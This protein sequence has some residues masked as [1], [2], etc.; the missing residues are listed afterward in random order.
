[1]GKGKSSW[2]I[3]CTHR[4]CLFQRDEIAL[5]SDAKRH[6][7]AH[8]DIGGPSHVVDVLERESLPT[9]VRVGDKIKL[10]EDAILDYKTAC[11]LAGY[12]VDLRAVR[13]VIRTDPFGTGGRTRLYVDGPPFMFYPS[14]VQLAWSNDKERREALGL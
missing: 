14:D 12:D 6:A 1:M 9:T 3:K 4:G 11:D 5:K 8:T 13:E 10:K 2:W 7:T